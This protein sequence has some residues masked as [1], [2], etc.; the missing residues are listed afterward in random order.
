MRRM[1]LLNCIQTVLDRQIGGERDI[2]F[3]R[4]PIV[5]DF[6][7]ERPFRNRV[8]ELLDVLIVI[9]RQTGEAD[10]AV[11]PGGDGGPESGTVAYCGHQHERRVRRHAG[12]G[13]C[14]NAS[15][16]PAGHAEPIRQSDLG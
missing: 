10:P 12:G 9:A 6:Q 4:C 5:L 1:E 16:N 3:N 7:E 11:Q 15:G 2:E 8:R 13:C 14:G